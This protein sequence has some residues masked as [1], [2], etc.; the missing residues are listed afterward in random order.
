MT[1]DVIIEVLTNAFYTTLL[2]ILPI[3]GVSLSCWN[4]YFNFPGSNVNSGNDFNFCSKDFSYR[5]Y[6]YIFIALD[7]G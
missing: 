1:E 5:S 7:D 6:N 4:Y 3:L 2:I